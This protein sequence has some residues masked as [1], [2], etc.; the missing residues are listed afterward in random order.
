MRRTRY[1]SELGLR[2]GLRDAHDQA[3]ADLRR[4]GD[5]NARAG[6]G[7]ATAIYSVVDSVLLR[8]L[9]FDAPDRIAAVWITQPAIANDPVLS[10]LANAT[11]MG[12]SEY[13]ALRQN[14]K[15]LRD[16]AM[17]RPPRPRSPRTTA[18]S[19]CRHSG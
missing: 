2:L 6:I 16:V 14:A 7:A 15:T 11:P 12:S 5:R 8:P 1:L 10:W 3:S 18:P 17:C 19:V 4:R 9:P 13:D